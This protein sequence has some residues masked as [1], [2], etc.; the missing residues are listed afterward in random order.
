M[1]DY[2]DGKTNPLIGSFSHDYS[3]SV[4]RTAKRKTWK[5]KEVLSP[6]NC[7]V[8]R[9][10]VCV[11]KQAPMGPDVLYFEG[12]F[13]IHQEDALAVADFIIRKFRNENKN[14]KSN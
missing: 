3:K 5:R 14:P 13:V 10:K 7:D 2:S 4:K 8:P 9:F 1:S 6:L 12:H 11:G